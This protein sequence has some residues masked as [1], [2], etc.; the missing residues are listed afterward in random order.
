MKK[1]V[2]KFLF[3]WIR[4]NKCSKNLKKSKPKKKLSDKELKLSEKDK[5]NKLDN[6]Q[7]D[8]VC[9]LCVFLTKNYKLY[10]RMLETEV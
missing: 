4:L 7:T 1:L 6:K 5:N 10:Q 8:G 2:W 3:L 9:V